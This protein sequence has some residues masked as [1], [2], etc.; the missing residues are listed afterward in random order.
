MIRGF[1]RKF[2]AR[3]R[4]EFTFH[5]FIDVT[6][7]IASIATVV[8]L[9]I[10]IHDRPE[11]ANIAAWQILQN[12]LQGD[13]RAGFDEGQSFALETLVKNGVALTS[14][15][16]H[17]IHL[18]GTNLRR[19]LLSGAS[20]ENAQLVAVDLT[21]ADIENV[22]FEGAELEACNCHGSLFYDASLRGAKISPG[23]YRNANFDGADISDL[24]IGHVK[25][26]KVL[27]YETA[28]FDS[29][30]FLGA[31]YQKGHEPEF[32]PGLRWPDAPQ[33]EG[34]DLKWGDKWSGNANTNATH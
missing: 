14:L 26:G 29:G 21:D 32:P 4:T 6:T 8:A 33:G 18:E 27:S 30:A 12:Y 16:A 10:L 13:K 22:N 9:V 2:G 5:F 28:G 23:D 3:L 20:F 31:C 34:C 24:Q 15:D 11:Q 17:A 25:A 7:L 19:A 1:F